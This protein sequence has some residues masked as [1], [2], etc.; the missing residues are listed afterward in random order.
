MTDNIQH[1][2]QFVLMIVSLDEIKEKLSK[3][4]IISDQRWCFF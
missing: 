1:H 2:S 4:V 3:L